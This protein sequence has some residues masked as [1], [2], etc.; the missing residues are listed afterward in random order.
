MN[1]PS[2]IYSLITSDDLKKML[3]KININYSNLKQEGLIRNAILELY[4]EKYADEQYRAFAEHPRTNGKDI[5]KSNNRVDLSITN[6][7]L[8]NDKNEA[9]T[10]NVELKY[11]FPKHRKK[12]LDYKQSIVSEFKD[13]KS[14]MFILIVADWNSDEKGKFDKKWNIKTDLSKYLSSDN[15][16]EQNL[17][18]CFNEV[19][20]EL[21]D[22]K[23]EFMEI[24]KIEIDKPYF[25]KYNF[26][27]IKKQ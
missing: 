10:Y 27:I 6:L 17:Q 12:F 15:K 11:H 13:R 26:Y 8:F 21:I 19:I 1:I 16:W 23:S 2:Q 25:T 5:T 7:K 9:K 4:N 24:I 14:D 3:E 20:C 18:D 22:Y